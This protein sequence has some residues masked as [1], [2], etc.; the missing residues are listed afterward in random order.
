M[1]V[2]IAV[3]L[4]ALPESTLGH[5]KHNILNSPEFGLNLL[6][7]AR[8]IAQRSEHVQSVFISAL[9]NKPARRFRESW[10]QTQDENGENDLEADGE[11]PG[12]AAGFEEREAEIDPVTQHDAED[13]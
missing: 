12:D 11:A 13:D 7:F 10:N 8:Q 9:Q 2:A 5:F 6:V 4:E 3:E 1:K